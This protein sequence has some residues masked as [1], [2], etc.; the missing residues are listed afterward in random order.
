MKK[1]IACLCVLL[2]LS[3]L[4][5]A[6][7]A[8]ESD[9]YAKLAD[10]GVYD[11]DPITINVY[12]QLANYSGIQGHWSADLLLDMFN[13]RINIIP[14]SDGTYATRMESKNLGDIVVWGADRKQSNRGC[15]W[16]G[17]KT[18]WCRTTRPIS[19]RITRWP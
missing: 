5:G 11:G 18:A 14:D 7:A 16:T 17:K 4:A 19:G 15:S 6:F 13:V 8:D 1:C 12:S 9:I 2:L 10:I 3:G